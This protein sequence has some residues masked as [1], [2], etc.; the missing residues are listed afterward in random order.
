MD[1]EKI[2][3]MCIHIRGI[4]DFIQYGEEVLPFGDPEPDSNQ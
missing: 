3:A 2:D 1:D 4:L